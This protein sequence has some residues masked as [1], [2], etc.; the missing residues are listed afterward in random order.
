MAESSDEDVITREKKFICR[1]SLLTELFAR[2]EH[3]R[4]LKHLAVA[5]VITA[6]FDAAFKGSGLR[7]LMIGFSGITVAASIWLCMFASALVVRLVFTVWS[8]YPGC[9]KRMYLVPLVLFYGIFGWLPA[10]LVASADWSLGIGSRIVILAEQVNK[11]L[12]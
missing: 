1:D 6:G 9:D 12:L 4:S 8:R 10:H 5:A 2:D 7:T 3:V 11:L